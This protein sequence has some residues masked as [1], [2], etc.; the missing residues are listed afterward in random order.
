MKSIAPISTAMAAARALAS[1]LRLKFDSLV[2]DR[3]RPLGLLIVRMHCL[4]VKI[5]EG[6]GNK[7]QG[8]NVE[9]AK[10]YYIKNLPLPSLDVLPVDP[11]ISISRT[12]VKLKYQS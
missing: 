6:E 3:D 9:N 5:V 11:F 10:R 7:S 2:Y 1:L 12:H 4:P 8:E